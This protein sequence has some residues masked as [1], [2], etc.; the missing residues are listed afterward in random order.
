[1]FGAIGRSRTGELAASKPVGDSERGEKQTSR[2]R[3]YRSE[4]E[5]WISHIFLEA[6]T[7]VY[8]PI[9]IKKPPGKLPGGFLLG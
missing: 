8:R 4:R 6:R 5:S 1:L 9:A 3:H 7:P 2:G